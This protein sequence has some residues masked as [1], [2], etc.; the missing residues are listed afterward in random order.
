MPDGDD[1]AGLQPNIKPIDVRVAAM[2][3]LA[4]RE[5]TQ[6]ELRQ[7][8]QRRFPDEQLVETELKKLT[9]EGLQSDRRFA[10]SFARQRSG[11]GYGPM[12]VRQDMRTRGLSDSEI[13]Q[14]I[15]AAEIDWY[16]LASEAFYK[17]FGGSGMCDLKEKARRVRFMQ[18][19]GFAADHYRHLIDD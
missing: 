8:L 11:R 10:E 6:R 19:R 3:L 17:K 7:K 5:H 16:A 4:R 1:V 15:E 9:Q 14:A 13:A 18:Y 2:N 12:R